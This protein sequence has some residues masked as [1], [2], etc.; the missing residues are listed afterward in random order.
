VPFPSDSHRR[1]TTNRD[2]QPTIPARGQASRSHEPADP[3]RGSRAPRPARG[4]GA[5]V[6]GVER[7]NGQGVSRGSW[8]ARRGR[9]SAESGLTLELQR[10][11]AAVVAR[12]RGRFPASTSG[13]FLRDRT[14]RCSWKPLTPDGERRTAT[15]PG[16]L[17]G[18][19]GGSSRSVV[20]GVWADARTAT[21]TGGG[22]RAAPGAFPGF[23]ERAGLA[24]SNGDVLLVEAAHAERLRQRP[25]GGS[26]RSWMV[27]GGPWSAP[28]GLT[29][30]RRRP[31]L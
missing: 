10:Q 24:R 8:V 28:S 19:L 3:I 4:S 15:A 18:I 2:E 16:R 11:R 20:G 17:A 22:G 1:S 30:E 23:H 14:A 7:P 5:A 25:Q 31:R 12:H 26:R 13:R 21:A 29:L 6:P 27:R 9:G